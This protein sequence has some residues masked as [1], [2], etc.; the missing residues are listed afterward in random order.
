MPG[1]LGVI[2]AI[3]ETVG[4]LASELFI[5]IG[6]PGLPAATAYAVASTGVLVGATLGILS[7]LK[8]LFSP[9]VPK[10]EAAG[11]TIRTPISS[12]V[13]GFGVARLGLLDQQLYE[14]FNGAAYD[15]YADH[16]GPITSVLTWYLNDDVIT[17]DG[18][19]D[20]ISPDGKKYV[21]SSGAQVVKLLH[22]EGAATETAYSE[23]TSA[24][25]STIWPS[26][27]RGDGVASIALICQP[28]KSKDWIGCYPNGVPIPT[29]AAQL[30]PVFDPRDGGQTQGT[31]ST[32]LWS[33]NP[34]LVLLAYLTDANG[35]M[36]LDYAR[37]I[38]PAISDWEDAADVCDE[39][40]TLKAGGT[41]PRYRCW[42][43]YKHDAP[44]ADV[45]KA[46]L[47]SMDGWLG[48]RGDGALVL[49]AGK[50][51]AP[52]VSIGA[53]HI[54]AYSLQSLVA[55]DDAINVLN[56]SYISAAHDY[57]EEPTDDWV[58]TADVA[59]RGRRNAQPLNVSTS[60][61]PGQSS[62]LAKRAMAR[63]LA[64]YRGWFSTDL[65]G[66]EGLGER[67][68]DITIEEAG[69]VIFDGP[70]EILDAIFTPGQGV[71]FTFVQADAN[72]D[73]W[74]AALEEGDPAPLGDVV[75]SDPIDPPDIDTAV[76]FFQESS[77]GVEGARIRID[78]TGP[79][80]PDLTWY[81]RWKVSTDSSWKESTVLDAAGYPSVTLDTDFVPVGV[82]I[83]VEVAYSTGAGQGS[84]WSST[85]TVDTSA[86]AIAPAVP[87]HVSHAGGTG[88]YSIAWQTPASLNFY[89]ARVWKNTSGS[90]FGS[91]TNVGGLRIAPSNYIDGYNPS[92]I[93]A[94]TYDLWVTAEN[95]A[96]AASSPIGPF[97]VTVT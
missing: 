24:L 61:S 48:Q 86:D 36:G 51:V 26:T 15:V 53:E 11:T 14:S 84:D 12:R 79:D 35:G 76:A 82:M 94:G 71:Q 28:V 16:D 59:A 23:L 87:I 72:I 88:T 30:Q 4:A 83:D 69:A 66:F 18:S 85:E 13:S 73:D 55:T 74:I 56:L 27:S 77:P 95:A 91:A 75:V 63:G 58:D 43:T 49:K 22:R 33:D 78:A 80:R 32:Y 89:G 29:R 34:A 64:P 67:Y 81:I 7:G 93:A 37:L 6:L 10:S 50:Y 54:T 1:V 92:G 68:L 2:V 25:G 20:V 42:I 21:D 3:A 60:P 5:A 8:S 40:V 38:A 65:A 90:G 41:E 45:I 19:D 52:T 44:P 47:A 31:R 97:T 46:I 9:G 62:R 57:A 39:A 70:V 17:I 96:A